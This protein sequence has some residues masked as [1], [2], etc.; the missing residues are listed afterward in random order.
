MANHREWPCCHV[1]L[2]TLQNSRDKTASLLWM[3]F[4]LTDI[5]S[6]SEWNASCSRRA[7]SCTMFSQGYCSYFPHFT[8]CLATPPSSSSARHLWGPEDRG[9]SRSRATR[10]SHFLCGR[11]IRTCT[12]VGLLACTK[13]GFVPP[14][15]QGGTDSG[16]LV[17]AQHL[18]QP[19]ARAT[20]A[21]SGW[22]QGSH[23]FSQGFRLKCSK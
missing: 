3:P 10:T 23:R 21:P 16:F 6:L 13:E 14:A 22:P 7:A 12:C 18:P 5:F 8:C 4:P 1:F 19:A 20:W 17:Q 15:Q 9:C 11:K 2:F